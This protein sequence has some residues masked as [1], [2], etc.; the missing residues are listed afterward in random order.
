MLV[1]HPW[2]TPL[3]Q[4]PSI[5]EE[6]EDEAS[7]SAIPHISIPKEDIFGIGNGAT[8]ADREFAAWVL[9]AMG[10]RRLGKMGG[11]AKPAL[12]QVALDVVSSPA[13]EKSAIAAGGDA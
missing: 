8:T 9:Q 12:H 10:R 1:R 3:M 13:V 11:S 5:A 7:P 2:L 4:P 6:D